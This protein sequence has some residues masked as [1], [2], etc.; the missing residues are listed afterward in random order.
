MSPAQ[1]MHGPPVADAILAGAAERAGEFE[2]RAG[3]KTCLAT[4][5]VGDDPASHTYVR[6]KANRCRT[7]GLDSRSHHLPSTSR[8]ADVVALIE[9]LSSD[10]T[11]DGI[12][13]QHPM[14]AHVDER[15]AFEAI[16]AG[17]D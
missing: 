12:L 10:D 14:P 8:T 15:E 5:L 4:V 9:D 17:K 7:A 16:A 1:L 11:V 6:M 2:K 13:V 3:R